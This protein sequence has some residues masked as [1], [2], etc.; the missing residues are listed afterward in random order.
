MTEEKIFK[1]LRGE[2]TPEEKE[3]LDSW[4][5]ASMEN[6]KR[7]RFARFVFEGIAMNSTPE[8]AVLAKEKK[9][10]TVR[11]IAGFISGVAAAVAVFFVSFHVVEKTVDGKLA[12]TFATVEVPAGQRMDLVLEDGTKVS[13]NSGAS[14]S[15]PT[16]FSKDYRNVR[17]SGEAYFDVAKDESRPFT[18]ETFATDVTVL[19][20][21]FNLV[22]DESS[23]NFRAMLVEGSV[24]LTSRIDPKESLIMKP[25]DMVL[26][27]GE[28]LRFKGRFEPE[29][30]CWTEGLVNIRGCDFVQLMCRFEMAYGVDIEIVADKIPQL[31]DI[32]GEIRVSDGIEHA[33][34]VLKHI[35]TFTYTRDSR[36]G[37]I[38]IK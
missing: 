15:Y 25:D 5:A 1:Y 7:Y 2:A 9:R 11:R 6:R 32:S 35:C 19:G 14:F 27:E 3:S 26:L 24:R 23:R 36:S 18:V 17:L 21:R 33:L 13:L 30:I 28:H 31:P 22:A 29:D 16:L 12:N 38:Y 34:D 20:T 37:T 4:L 8:T 10:R